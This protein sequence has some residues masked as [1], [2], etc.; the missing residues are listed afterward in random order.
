MPFKNNDDKLVK[1]NAYLIRRATYYALLLTWVADCYA[2]QAESM[3]HL[4]MWSWFLHTLY[5]ELSLA[6]STTAVLLLQGPSYSGAHALFVLYLWALVVNPNMEFDLA[7]PGRPVWLVYARAFWLHVTPVFLHW[8]DMTFNRDALCRIYR[9]QEGS[10][11]ISI[12]AS[13]GGYLS[14]GL[15]WEQVNG[16][17]SG[18]Y[19]IEKV[20]P[21]VF[22]NV[23]KALGIVACLLSYRYST[24][25]MINDKQNKRE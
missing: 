3:L 10:I 12:W 6:S 9:E 2:S 8:I 15:L 19:K 5:F 18:T 22:V 25:A 23:G 14:M 21:K 4:T 24:K 13:V 20:S 11:W 16:D 1:Y 7:P 17:A